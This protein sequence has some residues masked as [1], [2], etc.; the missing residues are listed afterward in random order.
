VSL[1]DPASG[2]VTAF[3]CP[4][5]AVAEARANRYDKGL[6]LNVPGHVKETYLTDLPRESIERLEAALRSALTDDSASTA[7]VANAG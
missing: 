1:R 5:S 2:E 3:D 7:A 4:R 6:W